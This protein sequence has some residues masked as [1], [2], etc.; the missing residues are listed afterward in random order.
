MK[1]FDPETVL[2]PN[3]FITGLAT[4]MDIYG[5]SGISMYERIHHHWLA[6]VSQPR[7]SAEESIRESI[8]TI[9]G[10]Y[11]RLLAENRE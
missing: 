6:T 11:L 1:R 10:E 7:Q 8:A 2:P 5:A 3:P 4:A 9:N